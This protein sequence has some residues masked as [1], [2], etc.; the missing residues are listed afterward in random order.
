MITCIK[1]INKM[2]LLFASK[3]QRLKGVYFPLVPILHRLSENKNYSLLITLPP[4]LEDS[5][6]FILKVIKLRAL[7]P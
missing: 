7:E 5:K 2:H 4:R 6:K 3:T 1:N